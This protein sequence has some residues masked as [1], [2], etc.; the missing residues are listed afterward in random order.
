MTDTATAPNAEKGERSKAPRLPKITFRVFIPV[1]PRDF[2]RAL[3]FQRPDDAGTDPRR[4]LA[5]ERVA[6]FP[7]VAAG[8]DPEVVLEVVAGVA[9][10][11]NDLDQ[12]V[13]RWWWE[14]E[15]RRRGAEEDAMEG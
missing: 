8:V 7:E 1:L 3:L 11:L 13:L 2:Q 14:T 5:L 15:R 6:R 4:V 9:P 10:L 12:V